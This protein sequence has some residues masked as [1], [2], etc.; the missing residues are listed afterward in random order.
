VS[1]SDVRELNLK[2]EPV[3]PVEQVPLGAR[4]VEDCFTL[5]LGRLPQEEAARLLLQGELDSVLRELL[6]SEEFL[7]Q[8]LTPLMLRE[9]L[10]QERVTPA[11]AHR[12]IDWCQRRLPIGAGTR[13]MAGA[14][15][16]WAQLLEVLLADA[17]LVGVADRLA[18]A[19]VDQLLRERVQ[20]QPI[21]KVRRSVVGAID[22]ASALEVR[23]WALDLCDKSTPVTLELYADNLFMGSITCAES[24]PDV[25]EAVGGEGL[26]GFHYRIPAS[27]RAGLAGG[28]LL[29]AIDSVSRERIGTP[30]SVHAEL[31]AG[32]D[33]LGT[34]RGE[35]V[36]LREI[37]ERIEARL[38][39]LGRA[40]SVPL[41]A[42]NEYW[43]RFYRP[44]V[45]LQVQQ[46]SSAAALSYRP[47]I[48]VVLPIWNSQSRLLDKAIESVRSQTY[49]RWELI[50]CDDASMPSDELRQ[51]LDHHQRDP[52][53]RLIEGQERGGIAVNTNRG[54]AAAGGDYIALL[55]H[56][57]ELAPEALFV[58]AGALQERRYGVVYSDEDRI[59]EDELGR[60][61]HHTPFFKPAF[62][63][64]L[65]L[66]MNY[67]C[68]LMVVRRDVMAATSGLRPQFD[69]AQDHDFLLRATAEL[70]AEDIR[71][72]P[73]ILYHWRVTAGSVSRSPALAQTIQT[74]IV[75][76]VQE[77]LNRQGLAA[78]AETHADPVGAARAFA[79]RIRWRLPA[80]APLV[81][82]IIP[83]RDR[84]DLLRPC[85]DS[86]L[87]SAAHYPGAIEVLIVDNDSAEPATAAWLA[88][89][90]D[91]RVRV[92]SFRG[93]FNWSAIN[94][95]AAR[96]ARGEV[97]IFLNND[98][99]VLTQDWCGEL[100]ANALRPDVGAVGARLLY[101]DG[102]LQHAGV[103][104]GV[105]GVAGHDSV[106]EAPEEGGYFGRSHLQRSAL[107]VTGACLATRREVFERSGGFDATHLK[108]AFNDVDYCLRLRD[109]GYRIVYNPFAVLYHF[110][111]KSRGLDLSEAKLARRRAEAATFRGRWRLIV[112]TD[113]FYNPHFERFARPFDRLRSPP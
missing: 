25:K 4:D 103:V 57:D 44:A 112:D 35:L 73:R 54:L 94:N 52:R 42:Y 90:T 82:I 50:I 49:D 108:V 74:N 12:L 3:N 96:E 78:A 37:L 46:R 72:I 99:V 91:P 53:V 29:T 21:S 92:L 79:T 17:D 47:L 43:E 24:R 97:L 86:V 11:P 113:P 76:V 32:L 19:Q 48:S 9:A 7:R 89:A 58:V 98:T 63:P 104:L 101:A 80:E 15:R 55:D 59:E 93:A 87:R 40:A 39:D 13:S 14:A 34:T 83:T 20:N 81:S 106:G 75:A 27:R 70:A 109:T 64:D 67:I 36:Q 100:T 69:G 56:D 8:V 31:T 77:H 18:N 111:S 16:T 84:L 10:P 26:C 66:S 85:V 38:P 33:I 60:T 28:R 95:S 105:E 88:E 5:F 51:L 65:L 1:R 45:D 6:E 22:A 71:H 61:V 62:D 68:H 2:F 107:A 30:V 41:E 23:G 110:E 102:T